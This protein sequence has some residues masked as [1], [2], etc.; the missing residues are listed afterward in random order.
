MNVPEHH[1]RFCR[2][3]FRFALVMVVVALLVGISFQESARKV[4]VTPQVPVGA[5]LEWIISLALVHGHLFI[6]GVLLPLAFTWMVHLAAS[7]D[8]AP[9]SPALLAW[10]TRLYIPGVCL[11]ALLQL[12]KGYWFV[13]GVRHGGDFARLNDSFLGGGHAM[14]RV[15]AFGAAH[16]LLG[17]GLALLVL[18]FWRA[19]GRRQAGQA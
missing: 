12:V 4:L 13:L 6:M 10:A 2:T 1:R 11:T 18:G 3:H 7:L 16:A 19:F 17:G 8:M 9:I 5:H 14:P 15:L